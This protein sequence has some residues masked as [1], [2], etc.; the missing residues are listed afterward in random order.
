MN[1]IEATEIRPTSSASRTEQTA[2]GAAKAKSLV[3]VACV[4]A[5]PLEVQTVWLAESL[6]RWGGELAE[7]EFIAVTPRRGLPLTGETLRAFSR[8]QVRHESFAAPHAYGWWGPMNKPA[9]LRHGE[10][11]SNAEV[12]VW[13]DSDTLILREPTG[14]LLDGGVDFAAYPASRLLDI[15]TNGEDDH[16]SY[17]QAV[18][19]AHGVNPGSYSWIPGQEREGG[20]IRMYWQS[21]VFAYKRSTGLGAK[22]LKYS[23]RQMEAKIAARASGIYFHEQTALG[24]ATHCEGLSCKVLDES[25][26]TPVNKLVKDQAGPE[27]LEGARIL[28][29]FGSAWPDF[30]SEMAAMI[31]ESRA[32]VAAWLWERGPLADPSPV[33]TRLV[34]RGLKKGRSRAANKFAKECT[35]I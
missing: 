26:N 15:G 14:L 34:A 31:R 23:E 17:W 29:Y 21:G 9:A 19:R 5:G 24:I 1:T 33:W 3:F 35:I 20:R 27:L 11:I 6:R 8:L 28:H 10:R 13:L 30:F 25:Y 32:D 16:E 7:S 22:M 4:E 12:V 18:C 2:T